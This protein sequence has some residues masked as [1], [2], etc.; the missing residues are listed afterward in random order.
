[1]QWGRE[2][3]VGYGG[4]SYT[5]MDK[6]RRRQQTHRA[7]MRT[8]VSVPLYPTHQPPRIQKTLKRPTDQLMPTASR[9]RED[10]NAAQIV[11]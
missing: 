3:E 4:S 6:H 7:H 9:R 5:D 2:E 11:L 10:T 8:Q 1:M